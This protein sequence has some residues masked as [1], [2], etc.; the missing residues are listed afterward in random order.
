[1]PHVKILCSR[2]A[3][4]GVSRHLSR[5]K[6]PM[7]SLREA[8]Q[9]DKRCPMCERPAF[10]DAAGNYFIEHEPACCLFNH[11]DEAIK[12]RSSAPDDSLSN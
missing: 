10:F 12:N 2:M 7:R 4:P 5:M 8:I 6:K 1:M 11:L 9:Q 3:D